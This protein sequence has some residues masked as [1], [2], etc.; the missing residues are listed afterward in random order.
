MT[1]AVHR[2]GCK[3]EGERKSLVMP[4]FLYCPSC[5]RMVKDSDARR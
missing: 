5:Q 3:R 1:D 4:D 2:K